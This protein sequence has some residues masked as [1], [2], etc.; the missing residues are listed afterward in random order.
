MSGD[1]TQFNLSRPPYTVP[2]PWSGQWYFKLSSVSPLACLQL[3]ARDHASRRTAAQGRHS[4][5]A[6]LQRVAGE[7]ALAALEA[8]SARR[9]QV[10]FGDHILDSRHDHL[11]ARAQVREVQI[12][13]VLL[14]SQIGSCEKR[15]V[16]VH[17]ESPRRTM[18]TSR[19]D[20]AMGGEVGGLQ[21]SGGIRDASSRSP[22]ARRGR[23]PA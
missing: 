7:R 8:L 10:A 22:R 13:V 16:T 18:Y 9:A 15:C 6:A 11:R 2:A 1:L 17:S 3:C 14:S 19:A 4:E 20:D 5:P 12:R 21:R 23:N